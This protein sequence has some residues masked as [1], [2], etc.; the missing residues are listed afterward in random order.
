MNR[1]VKKLSF[2]INNSSRSEDPE[3]FFFS[4]AYDYN[5][6]WR[7]ETSGSWI[8]GYRERLGIWMGPI[9]RHE[10]YNLK[11]TGASKSRLLITTKIIKS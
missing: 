3:V 5:E 11:L 8:L 9:R 10:N 1:L 6:S 2:C 4:I 7:L